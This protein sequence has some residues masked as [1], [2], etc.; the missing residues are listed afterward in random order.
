MNIGFL[1]GAGAEVGY[2]LPSGGKFALDIF[3]Y[4]S[5]E[6]KKKFK[7]MRDEIDKTTKYAS[8]WL[9]NDYSNNNISSYGKKV[10]ETIIRDT[11]EHNRDSII[12]KLNKFDE[13]ANVE[14]KN[15]DKQENISVMTVLKKL[16]GKEIDDS[17]MK[18]VISF[19]DVFQDGNK[20]F[21]N[22]YFSAV[23]EIYKNKDLLSNE[24]RI[25]LGKIIISILQLQIGALSENLTRKINDSL[26]AKKD[27]EIDI[28]DDLGEIIQLNYQSS[29]LA[30]IEYL[31]EKRKADIA[32][33]EGIVL[34]FAQC[35]IESI[36]ASV[37]DYKS[38]IDS[39]WHYLYCPSHEWAKFCKIN[40]FLLTVHEYI[41][42]QSEEINLT[43]KKGYYD[44]LKNALD[45]KQ[46]EI[47]A[48]A[49]TNYNTFISE[50]TNS[51]V[52]YMNGSTDK[53]YDPY[54]NKMGTYDE[55]IHEENHFLVPL[56]FTQSGTKP[57]T[58]IKMAMEYVDTYKKWKDSSLIVVIGFGFNADDEHINGIIRTLVDTDNKKLIVIK[59]K[60]SNSNDRIEQEIANKLKVRNK[61]NIKVI[62]VDENRRS[63][64]KIWTDIV[65][66]TQRTDLSA[67]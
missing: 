25:E 65:F 29:G 60:S 38:L 19:V 27:D 61:V 64:D 15:L 42:N 22:N 35:I 7:A 43:S 10:F 8:S 45:K 55:L 16:L 33:D 62:Q 3:R 30:G 56:M 32:T 63:N 13:F 24:I 28:F 41:L 6:S 11:I 67:L 36:Y 20:I 9:P 39:N 50:L 57:M 17:N 14:I 31:L 59:P 1:F 26:F 54:L 53:W 4:D 51:D 66:N 5:S 37:L 23:L 18:Q 34:R 49:T 52:I 21:E 44:D 12:A 2:G 46:F 48:I 40:I 58:S 47:S